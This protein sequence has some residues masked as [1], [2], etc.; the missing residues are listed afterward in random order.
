[1][2]ENFATLLDNADRVRRGSLIAFVG[3][4][5]LVAIVPS[6]DRS[7]WAISTDATAFL[8]APEQRLPIRFLPIAGTDALLERA[9]VVGT[10]PNNRTRFLPARSR[11]IQATGQST[12]P[13]NTVPFENQPFDDTPFPS[14]SN[15]TQLPETTLS[16][17][18]PSSG[19]GNFN[20]SPG[21]GNGPGNFTP[22]EPVDPPVIVDPPVSPVPEPATWLMMLLGFAVIGLALRRRALTPIAR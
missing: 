17:S 16:S 19:P 21:F 22:D 13:G 10:R 8:A 11:S 2:A 4:A 12:G 1:M 15:S 14:A 6:N 18:N 3:T 9:G 20:N 7:M 5:A